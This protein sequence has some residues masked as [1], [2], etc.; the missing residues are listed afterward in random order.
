VPQS[1]I[2]VLTGDWEA[3]QK[4]ARGYFPPEELHLFYSK[5]ARSCEANKA[6]Q[7]AEKAYVAAGELDMAVNMY[8]GNKMWLPMLKLVQQHRRE[9]LPQMH[10][11]VAHVSS[12]N[13]VGLIGRRRS[14]E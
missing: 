11:L 6:W 2:A 14:V 9:Q 7:D 4:V 1:L 12:L 10:L 8:K 3:A 13:V 5:R